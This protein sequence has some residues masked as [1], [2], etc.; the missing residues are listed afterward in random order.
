MRIEHLRPR[1]LR[2]GAPVVGLVLA[3]AVLSLG[4]SSNL[5]A[6]APDA[7]GR[8]A[9]ITVD[10]LQCPFCA[11]GIQKQLKKL[12]GATKVEVELAKNQA[13]VSFKPGA[14]VT[15]DQLREAVRKAGFTAD[16]IEWRSCADPKARP[17]GED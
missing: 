8:Q 3:A 16:T 7:V 5:A 17:C 13:I 14:D 15:D 11:Y 12:P 4:G 9:V 1:S 10:G 2:I 6:Q